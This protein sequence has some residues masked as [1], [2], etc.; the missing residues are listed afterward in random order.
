MCIKICL[1]MEYKFLMYLSKYKLSADLE[2]V[3]SIG[4]SDRFLTLLT[5]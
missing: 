2:A 3:L 1:D 4:A 5:I